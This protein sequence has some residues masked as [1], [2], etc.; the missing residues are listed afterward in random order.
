MGV[1]FGLTT[2]NR[3]RKIPGFWTDWPVTFH[4]TKPALVRSILCHG[5][6]GVPGDRLVDGTFLDS[7]NTQKAASQE[8]GFFTSP[9]IRYAGLQ[10]YAACKGFQHGRQHYGQVVLM[11]KQ[12]LPAH[13]PSRKQGETMG[14]LCADQMQNGVWKQYFGKLGI[15]ND[16][17]TGFAPADYVCPYHK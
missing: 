12:R 14:F 6:I 11:C 1:G 7:G 9:T 17:E 4:G 5:H 16:P 10:L 8:N 15:P 3:I 2:P 13:P